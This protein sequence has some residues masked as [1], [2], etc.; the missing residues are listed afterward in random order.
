M[1][2]SIGL[3][4]AAAI[5]TAGALNW[6]FKDGLGQLGTLLFGRVIAHRFDI[7]PRMWY[8]IASTKLNIAM[9]LEI[10]TLLMPGYFLPVASVANA[11]KGLAWMSGGSS[12]SAFNVAFAADANIADITAKATSQTICTS[13]IGTT[14]GAGIASAIG[15]SPEAAVAC[16]SV[17]AGVHLYSGYKSVRTVPL[18][19]LNATR[20]DHLIIN[21]YLQTNTD[22]SSD[23]N[24]TRS[25]TTPVEMAGIEPIFGFIHNNKASS[26]V[27]IGTSLELLGSTCPDRVVKA[28]EVYGREKYLII[29][30]EGRG[31]HLVF[32]V[33]ANVKDCLLGYLNACIIMS[34][35]YVGYDERRIV[36]KAQEMFDGMYGEMEGAGWDVNKVVLEQVKSARRARWELVV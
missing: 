11:L 36:V 33:D 6:V 24:S 25:M 23:N 19:T 26:G 1:L 8:L 29:K 13:L 32:H 7:A 34:G 31:V 4:S 28:M 30:E 10:S 15:Q 35:R 2:Y 12:R 3:G 17:V 5:P 18:S 21:D 20:L 9:L 14:L 16:F 22:N 27:R